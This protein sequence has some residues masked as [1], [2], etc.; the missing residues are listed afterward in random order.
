VTTAE[1][2]TLRR[3]RRRRT[4]GALAVTVILVL[5]GV[6]FSTSARTAHGSQLRAD[7]TDLMGLVQDE[8]ARVQAKERV[9]QALRAEVDARTDAGTRGDAT[10]Q[11]LRRQVQALSL[12]AG[13]QPATGPGL[14]VSLNDAPR[15]LTLPQGV[16]PDDLVVHQQDVQAVVNALWHGGAEAMMLM[17]QRVIST[18]AVRCVGNTLI[19]EGRVYSP[20]FTVTA[21]G[22][23]ALLRAALDQSE[24]VRIY[25]QYVDILGLGWE[26]RTDQ[27]LHLPAFDGSL[28]LHYATVPG[29]QPQ[30]GPDTSSSTGSTISSSTGSTTTTTA[31]TATSRAP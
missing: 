24:Q 23:P 18:S 17:D 30:S 9:V 19:L 4:V 31:G 25:R 15:T 20:P 3:P 13:L 28:D 29:Q 26:V 22:D 1:Q 11:E 14:V 2:P 10:A 27:Q 21:V 6:L 7:Q 8:S 16:K 12:T 5:A